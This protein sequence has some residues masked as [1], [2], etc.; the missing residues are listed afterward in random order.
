MSVEPNTAPTHG[1]DVSPGLQPT[2]CLESAEAMVWGN[3]LPASYS[4]EGAWK[5]PRSSLLR[6]ALGRGHMVSRGGI[7][8]TSGHTRDT[9]SLGDSHAVAKHALVSR[10]P[11]P[12]LPICVDISDW[13]HSVETFENEP[14]RLC[15]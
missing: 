7:G 14:R 15:Q 9:G 1:L 5:N 11:M 3:A 12:A 2:V 13:K 6:E 8:C 10:K 4:S